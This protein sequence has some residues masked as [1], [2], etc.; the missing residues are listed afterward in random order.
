MRLT[1]KNLPGLLVVYIAIV[2]SF[3]SIGGVVVN[4]GI[5]EDVRDLAQANKSNQIEICNNSK[6]PPA[7][8]RWVL[9]ND[10]RAQIK[11]AKGD[12]RRSKK[13]NYHKLFP[14]IPPD[15]LKQLVRRAQERNTRRI[16]DLQATINNL[17]TFDCEAAY[18]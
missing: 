9:A 6:R 18:R 5:I 1:R 12:I 4:R 2:V 11:Q 10:H 3:I 14:N 8:V 17:L 16:A 13:T 15:Q 7:G